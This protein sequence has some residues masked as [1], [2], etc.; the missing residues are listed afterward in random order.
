MD[1][2]RIEGEKKQQEGKLQ[3]TW[4]EAKD[5]ARD[6]KDDVEDMLD[7]S[8]ANRGWQLKDSV[9]DLI[10]KGRDLEKVVLSQAI[11]YHIK[12]KILVYGNR[13]LIFD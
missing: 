2:D 6:V 5:K 12:R 1:R 9:E 4:G 7:G 11:W 3:E 8:L 10:R 13:T